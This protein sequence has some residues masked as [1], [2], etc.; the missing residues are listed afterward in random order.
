MPKWHN[1]DHMKKGKYSIIILDTDFFSNDPVE[2]KKKHGLMTQKEIL[3]DLG[4]LCK[5]I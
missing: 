4:L 1:V 2:D 3:W 5:R